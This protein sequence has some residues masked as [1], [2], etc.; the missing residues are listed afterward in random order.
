MFSFFLLQILTLP[1]ECLNRNRDSSD[2]AT[3][4]FFFL[5]NGK[6]TIFQ[7]SAVQFWSALANSSLLFLFVVEVS[8]TQ[9]GLLLF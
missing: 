8:G 9:W 6:Q 7:S 4:F 5:E 2:Q 1:S 3:I